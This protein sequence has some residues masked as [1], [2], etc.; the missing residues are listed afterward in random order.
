MQAYAS[1]Q[2]APLEPESL[3]TEPSP[4]RPT[5]GGLGDGGIAAPW[6]GGSNPNPI[7]I[8]ASLILDG[9]SEHDLGILARRLLPHL[10]QPPE[11]ASEGTHGAYTVASLATELGVSQK[12]IRCAIA[13]RELTAV[14]RGARWLISGE[15]VREWVTPPEVSARRRPRCA[16]APKAAGPSLRSVL[17]PAPGN[18]GRR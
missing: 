8:L 16:P 9:L 14:K 6:A 3:C 7:A 13:R 10:R 12:T 18:G 15:A 4:T 11:P 5:R 2:L 1:A 17:C